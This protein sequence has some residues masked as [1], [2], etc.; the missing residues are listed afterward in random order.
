MECMECDSIN[1]LRVD[2]LPAL[3]TIGP[4][5]VEIYIY[6]NVY[7]DLLYKKCCCTLASCF[8]SFFEK[9]SNAIVQ[10][11]KCH[12]AVWKQ[13]NMYYCFDPFSRD[14][15]GKS[16]KPSNQLTVE[17]AVII[18]LIFLGFLC[19]DGTACVSMH[20]KISSLVDTFVRNFD[21]K[22][23]VFFVHALKV[24]KIQRDPVQSLQFPKHMVMDDF[25]LE[26]FKKYKMK[27]SKKPATEKPVTVDYSALA[28]RKLLAG[29][30]PK[31]SIFEVGSTVESLGMDQI[32]PMVHRHPSR[33]VLKKV[34]RSRSD[35][36]AD[37]DS[38]SL[39]D[40]QVVLKL[41]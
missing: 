35:I 19:R 4:Y 11:E 25:P 1:E 37:L 22:D 24:C 36:I 15:E 21:N 2:S 39:S 14:G 26:E 17:D 20:T 31:R 9:S 40:T 16:V 27:K 12:L 34:K 10:V 41:R 13:R 5:I 38:P 23:A 3:F 18:G 28:M 8:E 7:A 6:A 32:P 30:D 33:S 29:E